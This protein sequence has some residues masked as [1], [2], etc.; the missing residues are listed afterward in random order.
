M[1]SRAFHEHSDEEHLL[2]HHQRELKIESRIASRI[3]DSGATLDAEYTCARDAEPLL[4]S[5]AIPRSD[6]LLLGPIP[7][8]WFP[9]IA[10]LLQHVRLNRAVDFLEDV[11]D[12]ASAEETDAAVE[13][14][15]VHCD[16]D[17]R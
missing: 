16:G 1:R 7:P 5:Q 10:P 15:W 14:K 2:R 17:Q 3:S 11:P 4:R 6:F 9:T 8:K 13:V 12:V